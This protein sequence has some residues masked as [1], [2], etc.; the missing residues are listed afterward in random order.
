[1]KYPVGFPHEVPA[2]YE[3]KY[4]EKEFFLSHKNARRSHFRPRRTL[5]YGLYDSIIS[6]LHVYRSVRQ[7]VPLRSSSNI[8]R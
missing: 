2:L 5:S 6:P 4:S 8:D 3:R 7:E 1:M